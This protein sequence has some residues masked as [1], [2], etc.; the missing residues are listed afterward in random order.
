MKRQL[1]DL[2]R[3]SKKE[4]EAIFKA[5]TTPDFESLNGWEFRGYNV[6]LI[7]RNFGFQKFIKGFFKKDGKY[8]WG[9]NLM[10]D[11]KTHWQIKP[12]SKRFGFYSV[13][14]V[15][16]EGK[17]PHALILNYGEGENP[18]FGGTW[19]LRDYLVK[20]DPD[21]DDLYLGKAY[22]ALRTLRPFLNFFILERF[23][24]SD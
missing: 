12:G 9:Y 8:P 3:L 11:Q 6:F 14:P 4:L 2:A 19:I 18:F 10:I 16:P 7:A 21:N 24:K 23:R 13:K 17:E 15:G 20:V 22:L 5:G 1:E